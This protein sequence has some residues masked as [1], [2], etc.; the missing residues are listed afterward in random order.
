MS[1]IIPSPKELLAS[2]EL[3]STVILPK[4]MKKKIICSFRSLSRC[5]TFL[6]HTRGARSNSF[7]PGFA[8]GGVPEVSISFEEP[9]KNNRV[10]PMCRLRERERDIYISV[11][12][13]THTRSRGWK[14]LDHFGL[15]GDVCGSR[16]VCS[17]THRRAVLFRLQR[18]ESTLLHPSL[19]LFSLLL[20]L[21]SSTQD[22]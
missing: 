2:S 8:A 4:G 18:R 5:V 19:S 15:R 14:S 22:R 12:N 11:Y 3:S 7:A 13:E 6:F 17:C 21:L 9:E 20:L 10:R 1:V 16:C